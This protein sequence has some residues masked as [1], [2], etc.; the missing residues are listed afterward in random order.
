MWVGLKFMRRTVKNLGLISCLGLLSCVAYA[1]SGDTR[2]YFL[3]QSIED[4]FN[5]QVDI[6]TGLPQSM[7]QAPAVTTLI[8]A[9]QIRVM[10]YKELDEVLETVPGLHVGYS[11]QYEAFYNFRG[12]Y[13][14]RF[15]PQALMLVNGIPITSFYA[16]NRGQRWGG[17]PVNSIKRIEVLRGPGSALYGAE[18]FAGV[19]NIITKTRDDIDG[20]IAGLGF[21]SWNTTNAWVLHGAD[22]GPVEVAF[23]VEYVKTDG[24]DEILE[25][26]VQTTFDR[27]N[28]TNASLAPGPV[29]RMKK[30]H[31]MRLDIAWEDWRLRSGWQ[32]RDDMGIGIGSTEALDPTNRY[33]SDRHNIDITY[34][35]LEITDSF[36]LKAHVAYFD[37][38]TEVQNDLRLFPAGSTAILPEGFIPT[39][40]IYPD[41]VIGN[42]AVEE[43][44]HDIGIVGY[45]HG[46]KGHQIRI[47][48]GY[49][50]SDAFRITEEKN[51]GEDPANPGSLLP[52]DSPVV[53]VSDTSLSF[54]PE[55]DRENVH[56]LLQDVWTLDDEWQL[57]TG[58][59]YDHYSDFSS[60]MNPRAALVWTASPLLTLKLLYGEAFRA[61][62]L[63]EVYTANNP[64][65]LG[66]PDLE[67]ATM[68]TSEI[69]FDYLPN[70][71]THIALNLFYYEWLD[72]VEDVPTD[73][74]LTTT[75]AR[76]A[77]NQYGFGY[78]LEA[79]W[80]LNS[81]VVLNG[82][83]AFQQ[84]S[85][86]FSYL[87][88]DA[89]SSVKGDPADAPA[90]QLYGSINWTF[91]PHWLLKP[92]LLY[93][94]GRQREPNDARSDIEDYSLLHV[95]VQYQPRDK[96]WRAGMSI[97]N[98]FNADYREPSSALVDVDYP[99]SRRSIA[100]EFE[101][102]FN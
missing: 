52:T 40:P 54:L 12:V 85:R 66:N 51:F 90:H 33:G 31:E 58:L 4:L 86:D 23:T 67:P 91:A 38:S 25:S 87:Y 43:R 2:D 92:Q 14:S 46:F 48:V 26:D 50:R 30:S 73:M 75:Q 97:L 55:I 56:A 53:D 71:N 35:N 5:V 13:S 76:N 62:S 63:I 81:K 8:T 27:L 78:E 84:A 17:M 22:V 93:V 74:S 1:E 7:R 24:S 102:Q 9:E 29:S 79:V 36:G 69:A 65:A 57:T 68:K 34:Q 3:D 44:H 99:Q 101:Y 49:H 96:D 100:L 95:A 47:G 11:R 32:H 21:G 94:Q 16:G 39:A 89:T 64:V 83:W 72:L 19:I 10:G 98:L 28:G 6:A 70:S 42:P 20:T 80:R 77:T 82:H 18:A 61:P 59:R 45:F 88:P 60:T 41:G 37:S 15:N